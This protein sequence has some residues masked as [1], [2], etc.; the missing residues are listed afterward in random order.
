MQTLQRPPAAIN[1]IKT[2]RDSIQGLQGIL[3]DSGLKM[4]FAALTPLQETLRVI[5]R[6]LAHSSSPHT[7]P[8]SAQ[9]LFVAILLCSTAAMTN[10]KHQRMLVKQ[11]VN[12]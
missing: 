7:Y 4:L 11:A 6:Q 3:G 10:E 5:A 1:G 2:P 8:A 12:A 9:N